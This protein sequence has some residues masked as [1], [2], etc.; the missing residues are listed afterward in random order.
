VDF[1]VENQPPALTLV[2]PMPGAT[3][4]EDEPVAFSA[5]GRD[6]ASDAG[7]LRFDWEMDGRNFSG[8]QIRAAFTTA[9]VHAF[10]LSVTDPEGASA[11]VSG[12]VFVT[13]PP[14]ELLASVDAAAL[15]VNG[16]LNFTA[17]AT[18]TASDQASVA[19]LWD[20]GDGNLSTEPEG[21]HRFG[22][23]GTYKVRVTAEDDEGARDFST[24]T[25]RVD[26]RPAPP[27]PG[28]NERQAPANGP[29][30]ALLAGAALLMAAVVTAVIVLRRRRRAR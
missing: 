26:E 13:N 20:F 14:P 17:R 3:A 12:S 9:G 28:G 27:P 1:F 18:D 19:F 25:V 15:F 24:F 5:E 10:N 2:A 8:P 23:A 4:E 30:V 29:P 6:T 22:K 21:S 11:T 16:T 7:E